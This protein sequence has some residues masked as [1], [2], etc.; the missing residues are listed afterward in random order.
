VLL[1]ACDPAYLEDMVRESGAAGFIR[2]GRLREELVA[3]VT[4]ALARRP[5]A[6]SGQPSSAA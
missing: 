1:S 6:P 4:L 5:A 2:K 3:G